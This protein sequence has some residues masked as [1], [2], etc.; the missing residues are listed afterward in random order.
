MRYI[1]FYNIDNLYRPPYLIHEY[2]NYT[3]NDT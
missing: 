2:N 3:N 1:Y